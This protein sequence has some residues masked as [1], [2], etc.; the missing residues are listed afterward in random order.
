MGELS[1]FPAG[2]HDDQVDA[3]SQCLIHMHGGADVARALALCK[4]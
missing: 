1:K 3:L 4:L 2:K